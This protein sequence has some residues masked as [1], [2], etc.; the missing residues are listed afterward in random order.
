MTG[1]YI[2]EG[3]RRELILGRTIMVVPAYL[4]KIWK[5]DLRRYF[6]IEAGQIS[7]DVARDPRELDPRVAVW[8][9]SVGV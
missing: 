8:V 6:A 1:M 9:V 3:T 2:S 5:R 7:A 4:V